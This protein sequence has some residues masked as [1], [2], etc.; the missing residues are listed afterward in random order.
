[1][2]PPRR[3]RSARRLFVFDTP[4]YAHFALRA[5]LIDEAERVR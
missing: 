4:V 5:V 3:F 1:L 2:L